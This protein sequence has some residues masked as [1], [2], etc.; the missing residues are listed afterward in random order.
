MCTLDAP[1]DVD[2]E[3]PEDPAPVPPHVARL[4]RDGQLRQLPRLA[5]VERHLHSCKADPAAAVRVAGD[6]V[7]GLG[8]GERDLFW[9]QGVIRYF[10]RYA[11][12]WMWS[13]CVRSSL[14]SVAVYQRVTR[15]L[16]VKRL[17]RGQELQR[18]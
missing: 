13:R 3:L 12:D 4:L 2:L 17:H 8:G 10:M 18:R 14:V 6:G 11:Y 9:A 16:T 15:L 5:V 1:E 7:G